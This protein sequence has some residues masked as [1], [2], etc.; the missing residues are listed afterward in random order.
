MSD[1]VSRRAA[2]KERFLKS[3]P[4]GLPERELLELLLS[5][6]LPEDRL[7]PAADVLLERFGS[8]Y[9]ILNAGAPRLFGT[10]GLPERAACLA[11]LAGTLIRR[12]PSDGGAPDITGPAGA[13]KYLVPRLM[14]LE[15]EMM[16]ALCLDSRLRLLSCR[17]VCEG[18]VSRLSVDTYALLSEAL[19][20]DADAVIIAHN[21][22]NGVALPSREDRA[23]TV[24]LAELLNDF[25]IVLLDH[26]VIAGSDFVSLASEKIFSSY[27]S[28]IRDLYDA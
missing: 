25:G 27:P 10:E 15:R 1:L 23:T 26:L 11:A 2:L 20:Q 6:V 28:P 13:G 24:S 9:G 16:Y 3:S 21:H 18:G 19:D 4:G 14:G 5:Y 8:L 7:S 22:P 12:S 17:A